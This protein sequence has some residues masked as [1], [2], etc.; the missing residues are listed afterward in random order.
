MMKYP[1]WLALV[2]LMALFCV[3]PL[4]AKP[5]FVLDPKEQEVVTPQNTFSAKEA[6]EALGK[7]TCT[8]KGVAYNRQKSGFLQ[9]KHEKQYLPKG[10]K[11]YLF[12][13]TSYTQEVV[14]FFKKYNPTE[15]EYSMATLQA[16]T[17]LRAFTGEGIPQLLPLKRME[18]DPQFPKIWKGAYV[19]KEGQF[20]FENL[21]PGTY[22]LQSTKY[23][24]ARHHKWDEQVGEDVEELYWSDGSVSTNSYPV[25]VTREDTTYRAVVLVKIVDLKEDGQVQEIELNQDWN[26]FKPK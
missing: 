4:L 9:K 2:S 23:T 22:Y 7:G 18:L 17:T 15:V 10:G 21:K 3:G 19:G 26:D 25:W 20:T 14:K 6:K 13:Y 12:P 5:D 8:I 16:E 11:I 1:N 24:V